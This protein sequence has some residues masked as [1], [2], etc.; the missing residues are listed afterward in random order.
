MNKTVASL[1]IATFLLSP[2]SGSA[3]MVSYIGSFGPGPIPILYPNTATTSVSLPL[4]DP[5]LGTL[6]QVTLTLNANTSQ[7]G[8][9]VD[10]EESVAID[11]IGLGVGADVTATAPGGLIVNAVAVQSGTGFDIAADNDIFPDFAGADAFTVAGVTGTDS[12]S[13]LLT[14]GAV[15]TYIG[16]GTFDIDIEYTL[17]IFYAT[18]SAETSP[19]VYGPGIVSGTVTVAYEYTAVPEAGSLAMLGIAGFGVQVWPGE[20]DGD[21]S[22]NLSF[23]KIGAKASRLLPHSPFCSCFSPRVLF[24]RLLVKQPMI[25]PT[26]VRPIGCNACRLP[27][28]LRAMATI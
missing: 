8:I 20:S 17:S 9:T 4:F 12:D 1:A 2:I 26:W 21:L 19:Y 6:S 5:V 11:L 28:G 15:A 10:N 25:R 18:T 27:A 7:G 23:E 16:V 3:A 13:D 24:G 14:G 22:L